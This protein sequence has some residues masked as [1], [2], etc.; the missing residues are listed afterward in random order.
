MGTTVIPQRRPRTFAQVPMLSRNC[1]SAAD[2]RCP[3]RR[4][5]HQVLAIKDI[6]DVQLRTHDR[7]ANRDEYPALAFTMKF[8]STCVVLLKSNKPRP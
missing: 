1:R 6:V 2:N 5:F 7:S 4:A 8:G 3:R